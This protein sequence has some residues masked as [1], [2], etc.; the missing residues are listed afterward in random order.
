MFAFHNATLCL[1]CIYNLATRTMTSFHLFLDW[2]RSWSLLWNHGRSQ[3]WFKG[4]QKF[5]KAPKVL[6]LCALFCLKLPE[7]CVPLCPRILQLCVPSS[8]ISAMP[9]SSIKIVISFQKQTLWGE[10]LVFKAETITG[11]GSG[12]EVTETG[13]DDSG[14]KANYLPMMPGPKLCSH[15]PL[16]K[17]GC[18]LSHSLSNTLPSLSWKSSPAFASS[19]TP[20]FLLLFILPFKLVIFSPVKFWELEER[21]KWASLC[22]CSLALVGRL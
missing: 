14:L 19:L 3:M 12:Q 1:S 8:P 16:G 6:Q 4:L 22:L 11:K 7:L 5:P 18:G 17:L 21:K 2:V 15:E 13:S 10:W 20:D 9:S